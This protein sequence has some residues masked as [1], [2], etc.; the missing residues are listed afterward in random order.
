MSRLVLRLPQTLH[1]QLEAQSKREGVS[2]K[3]YVV[4]ALSRRLTQSYM[5]HAVPEEKVAQQQAQFT[6]L[7]RGLGQ[8]SPEAIGAILAAQDQVASEPELTP[9]AVAQLR[10]RM[11]STTSDEIPA[12]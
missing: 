4:Y 6:A 3:Q 2:L 11:A 7:L 5:V 9:D 1:R 12:G 8:A 10:A